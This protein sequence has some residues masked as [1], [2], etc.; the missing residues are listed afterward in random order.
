MGTGSGTSINMTIGR[1][2][3]GA[4]AILLLVG[5]AALGVDIAPDAV[6]NPDPQDDPNVLPEPTRTPVSDAASDGK[7]PET[8]IPL[9]DVLEL[10]GM[11]LTVISAAD[12]TNAVK[13]AD[14]INVNPPPG[15][16]YLNILVRIA[17]TGDPDE[18]LQVSARDFTLF[19]F[20]D[21]EGRS[22]YRARGCAWNTM[23]DDIQ[24]L[25]GMVELY[26][27]SMLTRTLCFT[28]PPDLTGTLL[29]YDT[30]LDLESERWLALQ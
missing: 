11:T 25:K 1:R 29:R 14:T 18:A 23:P 16:V 6:S 4:A 20:D 15:T 3:I 13:A 17:K 7:S 22:L 27:N 21:D 2:W 9:G 10:E 19:D 8:S 26:E 24:L 28:A 12:F 5:L 30:P